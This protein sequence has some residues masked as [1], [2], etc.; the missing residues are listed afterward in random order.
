MVNV[1]LEEEG[2]D[3]IEDIETSYWRRADSADGPAAGLYGWSLRGDATHMVRLFQAAAVRVL[4]ER[5][6]CIAKES[7]ILFLLRV[8]YHF[9][10]QR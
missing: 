5:F 1:T 9:A 6:L 2:G 3:I 10:K 7:G 4:N 8:V